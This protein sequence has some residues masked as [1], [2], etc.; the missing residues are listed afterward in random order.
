MKTLAITVNVHG[1]GPELAKV[2]ERDLVG[3][4]S[5]GRYT[6]KVGLARLLDV[7]R[8]EK[9][10]ATFFWPSSEAL[11][12]PGLLRRCL[13]EGH[14]IASNGRAF[15]DLDKLDEAQ[16]RAVLREAHETLTQL[17]GHPPVGFRAPGSVSVST[18]K[19]VRELGY[20]YDSSN[21]D[22]DA[23]YSLS[24]GADLGPALPRLAPA[25]GL[26][27]LP[28]SAGLADSTHFA[29]PVNQDRV[30]TLMTDA[31]EGLMDDMGWACLTLTPRAD[32]GLARAAR[33][34][35]I[36]RLLARVRAQDAAIRLCRDIAKSV[37]RAD[38]GVTWNGEERA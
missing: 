31:L 27:E 32:R 18:F 25:P 24:H 6:Y 36:Q 1:I 33:V 30:E 37:A 26:V 8:A 28:W 35:V 21:M 10:A 2:P 13:D 34:P 23:P 14:E 15:E 16:E 19:I 9:V 4:L 3:G 5:H 38:G 11:R 29:K 7:F 17:C 22:D 12:V 20:L